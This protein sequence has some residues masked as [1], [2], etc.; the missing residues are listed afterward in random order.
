MATTRLGA[1]GASRAPYGSFVGKETDTTPPPAANPANASSAGGRGRIASTRG[2]YTPVSDIPLRKK[3]EKKPEAQPVEPYLVSELGKL[4]NVVPFVP[5]PDAP[6]VQPI[7]KADAES[8]IAAAIKAVKAELATA[9]DSEES[10]AAELKTLKVLEDEV[11]AVL[12]A[13]QVEALLL[14]A[15]VE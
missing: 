10:K 5:P 2:A 14:L 7:T 11:E 8:L 9:K 1:Y 15:L 13:R 3:R 4:A 6:I 12:T